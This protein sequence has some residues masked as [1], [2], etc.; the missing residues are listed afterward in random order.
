MRFNTGN[1]IGPDGSSD[2]RDLFDTA[3][4]ADLLINGPAANVLNRLG[5]PLKSWRSI[6]QQVTD[7]LIDQGYESTYLAYG[8]GVVVQRQTQLVQRSGELYRVTNASSIPLTLT[9]TW[10]TDAPKLQAVGDAALRQALAASTG[11]NLIGRGAG[12]L[13]AALDA[14]EAEN[15]TQRTDIDLNTA[16][17]L[18]AGNLKRIFG[19][20]LEPAVVDLHFGTLAGVGWAET[21]EPGGIVPHTVTGSTGNTT[22]LDNVAGL[23]SGQLLCYLAT[24]G[25][26]YTAVIM[27]IGTLTVTLDR[28]LPAPVANGS[29]LYNFYRDDA[30]A[31]IYGFNAVADDALLQLTGRLKRV[32]YEG[33]DG[34]IWTPVLG[35]TLTSQTSGSYANPGSTAVGERAIAV[36]GSAVNGGAASA[37]VALVGGDYLTTVQ[38]N[39]GNR[40]G[41]FSGSVAISI[42]ENMADDSTFIIATSGTLLA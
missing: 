39:P 40:T 36:T 37:P 38:M 10:A 41:G 4:T 32:E 24:D 14:I 20:T 33:K 35:A 1:P 12:T 16:G 29:F 11:T 19:N 30:H 13:E 27:F 25:T 8:A 9:G 15:Q 34:A 22:I 21:S 3:A 5:V 28:P 23:F 42:Q 17:R 6:M 26:Y 7:Y 31:N 18:E 2:P